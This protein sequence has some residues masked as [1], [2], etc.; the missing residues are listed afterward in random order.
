MQ[1]IDLP[2]RDWTSDRPKPKEPFFGP[3]L[4]YGV[5]VVVGIVV[6]AMLANHFDSDG[7][8]TPI[9]SGLVAGVA[10][11]IALQISGSLQR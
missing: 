3:G 1:E 11:F 6:A 9:F 5:S 7:I 2:P 4:P 10:S 8:L